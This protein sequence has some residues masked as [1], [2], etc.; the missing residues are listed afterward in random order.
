MILCKILKSEYFWII[1]DKTGFLLVKNETFKI[2][3]RSGSTY[4]CETLLSTVN[5]IK[6]RW[7]SLLF[8]EHLMIFS[9]HEGTGQQVTIPWNG[10]SFQ[11]KCLYFLVSFFCVYLPVGL[12][13]NF[14]VPS[15]SYSTCENFLYFGLKRIN[16]ILGF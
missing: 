6:S 1:V 4:L 2:K 13:K 12:K 9:K 11:T 10:A 8:D 5:I 15:F 7:R 14:T 3:S 16:Y